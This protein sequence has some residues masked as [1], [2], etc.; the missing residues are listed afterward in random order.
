MNQSYTAKERA[1]IELVKCLPCS[2][3][4]CPAP[5]A[6]HHIKQSSPYTCVALCQSCHQDS[7]NGIHGRK[8]MWNIKKMD[9]LDALDITI[10]RIVETITGR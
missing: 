5:S 10:Q 9:E 7:H 2:V 8:A 4:D 6:A 1:Y 3:C